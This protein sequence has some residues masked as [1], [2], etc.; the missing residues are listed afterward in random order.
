M[1][2]QALKIQRIVIL[3][4][5]RRVGKTYLMKQFISKL[6]PEFG[7][8][9]VF[10]ASLDHP[11]LRTVSIIDLLGEFRR[12]NRVPRGER[13]VLLLDEVQ[14]RKGFEWE[15]KA[16]NDTEENLL[17]VAAGSSSLV[18]RHQSSALTGR[19]MKVEVRP[20]SFREYLQFTGKEY[21]HAEPELMEGFME[22]YL[23]TGGMPQYV[24]T[25]EPQVL[26]NIVED[27]I[28]RD[29]AGEQGIRDVNKLNDLFYLLMDRVG[30]PMSYARIGR[31]IGVGKDAASRY[32]DL[33]RR[34][35]LIEMCER[36][37]TP[38]ER[39]FSPKKVYCADNGFRVVM[40]GTRG[41][42]SLAEN[43][44]F[45]ILKRE[46]R[47]GEEVRYYLRD[48]KEVDF[49]TGDMAVEVK[50]RDS[51]TKA[52]MEGLLNLRNRGIKK[53]VVLTRREAEVPDGIVCIPL[54][55][56]AGE[57]LKKELMGAGLN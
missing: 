38:N 14:H 33:F 18:V 24:L 13:Q 43:L 50:Y 48:K 4:G 56:L 6:L 26:L 15:L 9:R 1:L 47:A 36:Y 29:I 51:V 3:Y 8:N 42:G 12:L 41:I 22:D 27:V 17:I 39:I 40:T 54:W 35:F 10:Y 7:A 55:R 53:R 37:G 30:R 28:Y 45:N 44:I 25:R 52:E 49:V 11:N 46:S 21:S 16:L 2:G 34:T 19:Y 5:L 32:V 20:L 31:L 57:G 23:I